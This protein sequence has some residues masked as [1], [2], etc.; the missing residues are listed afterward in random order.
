MVC[1]AFLARFA[2]G[3]APPALDASVAGEGPAERPRFLRLG[4]SL[5]AISSKTQGGLRRAKGNDEDLKMIKREQLKLRKRRVEADGKE[6]DV[7][8]NF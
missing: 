5:K 6:S 7:M 3:W 1:F 2:G 8:K 4:G